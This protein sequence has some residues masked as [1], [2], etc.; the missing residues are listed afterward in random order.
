MRSVVQ[1]AKV[2][3][4]SLLQSVIDY[5]PANI[6]FIHYP[7]MEI[8]L[9]NAG[10]KKLL[11][12][13]D[14]DDH[15]ADLP[16]S[17]RKRIIYA[18]TNACYSNEVHI[19]SEL[20]III[21]T[22]E[23]GYCT[24]YAVPHSQTELGNVMAIAVDV[25]S[26]VN[27]RKNVEEFAKTIDLERDR[28]ATVLEITPMAIMMA[29]EVGNITLANNAFK[30]FTELEV[31]DVYDLISK[32]EGRWPNTGL[33]VKRN[34]WPIMR[35]L[36][37]ERI[38][39]QLMDIRKKNG[40]LRTVICS[41][42][43]I[44]IMDGTRG[45]I[46]AFSDITNQREAEEEAIRAKGD[47]ELYLDLLTHNVNNLNAGAKGYLELLL[48]ND[49]LDDKTRHYASSSRD[50]MA[51]IARLIENVRKLQRA[52]AESLHRSS[53]DVNMVIE[54]VVS[55]HL[56]NHT[57]DIKITFNPAGE[58]LVFGNALLRD[59]FDNIVENAI[60]HSG[61]VVE[62]EIIS[63]RFMTEGKEFVRI[64]ITDTGPGISDKMKS[65]LFNRMQRGR[66]SASGHG[67]GL[68]LAKTVLEMF[69][70]RIWADD[71][72]PG[73]HSRG[74]RFIVLLPAADSGH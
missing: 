47:M 67:L 18:L 38:Y 50:L 52:E 3:E 16:D 23:S 21:L 14:L 19:E 11:N 57:R 25:T 43:P 30:A 54:D 73:D 59:V 56:N 8:G 24:L 68:Y 55:S 31:K 51:D 17:V 28:L 15:L 29:D 63:G 41:A 48:K 13:S 20:P 36:R 53:M 66:T 12:G 45:A 61:G 72:I 58:S 22:G 27:G 46:I 10:F 60:K 6:A 69:G 49:D 35:A 9:M 7:E 4:K 2:M 65:V 5:I 74:A 26:L 39:D 64:D 70:A 1:S 33:R 32:L 37:G 34:E 42:C 71:R 44:A 62:V 40:E